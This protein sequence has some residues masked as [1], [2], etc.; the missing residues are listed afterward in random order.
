MVEETIIDTTEESD[1][2]ET[3]VDQTDSVDSVFH[4]SFILDNNTEARQTPVR[5][6][7]GRKSNN[8][9]EIKK[10]A[11]RLDRINNKKIRFLSH[12]EFLEKCCRD[13]LTPNGLKINL[14]PSIGNKNEEFVNQGYKIQDDCAKQLMKMTIKF[15]ETTIKETEHEIKEIDSK[16][17]SNLPCTEYSNIKGQVSKDEEVT[18][19]QLRR[20]KTCKY[21][22][23]K[24]GEHTGKTNPKLVSEV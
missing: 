15:C 17:P 16:L 23:L 22:Q 24:Y 18:I 6:S 14:E 20:K 9:E 19:Q 12:K 7:Q 5:R 13:K 11:S 21:P 3:L 8:E 10:V 2:S 4:T 1:S